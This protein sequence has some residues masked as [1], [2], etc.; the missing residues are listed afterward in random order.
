MTFSEWLDQ[1]KGEIEQAQEFVKSDLP[2][3][4]E[5]IQADLNRT[6][7][8]YPRVAEMMADVDQHLIVSRAIE[9]LIVK[10]EPA[11]QDLAAPERKIVVEARLATI[12]RTRD[13]LKTTCRALEERSY[14]LMNHR[15]YE[16]EALRMAG[17]GE[18]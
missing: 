6:I 4:P 16:K 3:G 7:R 18:A 14:A 15:N 1:W 12:I 9:T 13:I 8:E 11:Y 2:A 5:G 17:H 10:G